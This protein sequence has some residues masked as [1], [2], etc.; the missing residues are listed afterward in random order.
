[1]IRRPP[2]STLFPYTTLFRSPERRMPVRFAAAGR[3]ERA[4]ERQRNLGP[5]VQL[6][7]HQRG[8]MLDRALQHLA[9]QGPLIEH[10]ADP[11]APLLLAVHADQPAR[12][13]AGPPVDAACVLARPVVA[14]RMDLEPEA[15]AVLRPFAVARQRPRGR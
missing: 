10:D 12:A 14:Q 5:S 3:E 11:L 9:A 7:R 15:D 13:R 2:R 4:G 1:M 8:G 6:P